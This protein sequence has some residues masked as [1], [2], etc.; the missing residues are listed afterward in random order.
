MDEG[1]MDEDGAMSDT[2]E[3]GTD[4]DGAMQQQAAGEEP[5]EAT[6]T[7]QAAT[8]PAAADALI[9]TVG[10]AEIRESD[11]MTALSALPPQARQQPPRVLVPAVVNQLIMR[12]L[13]LDAAMEAGLEE[14][15]EVVAIAGGG[16]QDALEQAL[17][18]VWFERELA[19]RI[20]DEDIEA[21][22][23]DLKAANPDLDQSLAEVRPQIQNQ[24]QRQAAAAVG[25][26]LREDAEIVFYDE[27][28]SPVEDT[29][30]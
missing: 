30:Q 12:E 1:G 27:T 7:E 8:D 13:V 6:T 2:A 29:Q 23:E 11:V 25:T 15:P 16:G 14:D 24:L 18:R 26:E 5:D 3:A 10:E 22:Y 17:V 28:G 19:G 20:T 21:A 9:V 4:E